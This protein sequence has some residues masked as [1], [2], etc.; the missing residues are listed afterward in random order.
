MQGAE[1]IFPLYLYHDTTELAFDGQQERKPNLDETIWRTIENYCQYGQAYK[2]LTAAEQNGQLGF[3]AAPEQPHFLTP[4]QIFDYIYGYLHSPSYRERY[5]EFL[6]V[7]FPRVPY[8][9]NQTQFDHIATIGHQLRELHLMHGLPSQI[10]YAQFNIGGTDKV[11]ELRYEDGKVWINSQQNFENVPLVAWEF[12]IGGYQPAQKW[13]KDRKADKNN[14]DRKLS[15]DDF[16][17][18][19]RIIYV[20]METDRLMKEIDKE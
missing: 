1:T 12:F 17:H 10:P 14:P 4:E 19:A 20:L 5:K 2:P 9:K 3:D 13:L 15:N 6:K 11:E 8:P 18:Y 16:K 7:D